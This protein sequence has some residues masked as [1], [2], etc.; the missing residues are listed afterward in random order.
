MEDSKT[1]VFGQD[2]SLLTALMPLLTQ[3]GIDAGTLAAIMNNNDGF[4]NNGWWLIFL[5]L[6]CGG[7]NWGNGFGWGGNRGNAD[8][9]FLANQMNNDVGRDLLMQATQ[10]NTNAINQLASTLNCDINS[11]KSA[12][13]GLMTAV[14]TVG[15][16]V[17]MSGLQIQNAV[18][19]GDAA[20]AAQLAQCCCENRLLTTQQGYEAQLRTLEQTN[21]LGSQSDRNTT[22]ILSAIKDQN[23]MI[24]DQFCNLERRELQDKIATQGD[25]ITQLRGQL[26]NDRQ[27]TQFYNMISP[28]QAKVNEIANK[29]PQTVPIQWPNLQAVNTTPYVGSYNFNPYGYGWS[30][31]SYWG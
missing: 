2:N 13:N 18:Q 30:G 28:L 4:G 19:A 25:I 15:S 6:V 22:S 7:G 24:V 17:G 11:V 20:L 21:Q 16:Q 12:L 27:T 23:A 1:Y 5:L 8:T 10:G 9:A 14:Q 3:K 29:Q 26:D 31:N